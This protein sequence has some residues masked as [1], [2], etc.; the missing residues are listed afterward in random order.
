MFD[1]IDDE[2]AEEM[3][4]Q[5]RARVEALF[6][7]EILDTAP[8]EAFDRIT[9]L[10]KH[11][12]QV[13]VAM[14]ALL[15]QDRRWAK[16][17]AGPCSQQ[18][19]RNVSFCNQAIQADVPLIVTDAL[20]DPAF[21]DSPLVTG[22]PFIRFYMGVPL[23]TPDG[24]NI[25]TLCVIDSTPH[26]P[27][28]EQIDGMQD[29]ASLIMGELE[30]RRIADTDSLTS[31]N[32]RRSFIRQGRMALARSKRE[33]SPLSLIAFDIDHFKAVNDRF[34]HG[35]GDLALRCVAKTC[36]NSLRSF[37]LIGRMGG[38][39]FVALLPGASLQ[40]ALVTAE[41]LMA[42]IANAVVSTPVGPLK[43]TA[44]FGVSCFDGSTED[45]E[46]ILADAD[47]AMYIAKRSGRNRVMV[48]EHAI[49]SYAA[50]LEL[51]G[52]D[53]GLLELVFAFSRPAAPLN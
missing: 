31:L 7:Y 8:E 20:M 2:L 26:H 24:Y 17:M 15:D 41:R 50:C 39:E 37:D 49:E 5:E 52:D 51:H 32:T 28:P 10:A 44:S 1:V 30:L 6:R 22:A 29:L 43:L 34:G 35:I 42:E 13:P 18:I 45:L 48:S 21:C 23:T 14:I 9:R 36:Q 38:E 27:G 3:T 33:R 40:D 47:E 46:A 4:D 16:S 25:G 53:R 11:V 12:M 19:P